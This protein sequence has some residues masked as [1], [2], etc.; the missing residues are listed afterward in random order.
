M[1][2]NKDVPD[3]PDYLYDP[4]KSKDENWQASREFY[5]KK[6][7]DIGSH[8]TMTIEEAKSI[9]L[10]NEALSTWQDDKGIKWK[11]SVGDFIKEYPEGYSFAVYPYSDTNPIDP[12]YAIE[13]IV[14]RDTREISIATKPMS[15][16][17]IV[18]I[19]E[20]A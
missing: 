9:L 17:A 2:T 14:F 4:Q 13:Y 18:K 20:T 11:Y 7:F 16:Q 10:K 8:D 15:K 19:I 12:M 6:G 3:W 5:L 1:V